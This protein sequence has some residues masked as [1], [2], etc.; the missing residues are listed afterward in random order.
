MRRRAACFATRLHFVR[1][2]EMPGLKTVDNE[3]KIR[4]AK[5]KL[6]ISVHLGL[7]L[8]GTENPG[9]QSASC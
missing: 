8:G 7:I 2:Y 5:E 6:V 9:G 4:D 1:V 3:N